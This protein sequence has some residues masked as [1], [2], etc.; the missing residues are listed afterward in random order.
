MRSIVSALLVGCLA[1]TVPALS[2]AQH[3]EVYAGACDASAAVSLT[4]DLFVVGNDE[5]NTLQTYRRG[6]P[7]PISSLPLSEFLGTGPHEA[8]I[9][10]A[11]QLG[12]RIYWIASHSRNSKGAVQRSRHRLFATD[13]LAGQPPVLKPAGR[14]YVHLLADLVKTEALKPLGLEAAA[15]LAAEADGGLNIEGLAVTPEG[16]LLIGLRNPLH[17]G[18]ALV[19]PLQNPGEVIEGQR[20]RLGS[21][22]ELDLGGRGVRSIE[23]VGGSY[24]IVAGPTADRGSFALYRWSGQA[25]ESPALA[26]DLGS[27]GMRPEALMAIPQSDRVQLLSD[28][29]GILVDG[30]ECKKLPNDK[31]SFR[32]VTFTP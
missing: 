15:R 4:E 12:S 5:D 21:A 23:L 1:G 30:I 16:G 25:S 6:H 7:R 2:Q 29:G 32:S 9:E 10:G 14:P 26:A 20:A 11:A 24:L 22:I 18:R 27:S 31:Q 19:V 3:I 13:I 8:D 28:D 17:A